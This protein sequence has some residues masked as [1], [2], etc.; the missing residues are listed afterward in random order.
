[1]KWENFPFSSVVVASS[2]CRWW[3]CVDCV[4]HS[5]N[6]LQSILVATRRRPFH[7][8]N[9]F[10]R[11]S[12]NYSDRNICHSV[13]S[14][15]VLSRWSVVRLCLRC[16]NVHVIRSTQRKIFVQKWK[17]RFAK[18]FGDLLCCSVHC[19]VCAWCDIE[20][21]NYAI[22][23]RYSVILHQSRVL[24]HSSIIFFPHAIDLFAITF[25]RF[26]G[27]IHVETCAR[28]PDKRPPFIHEIRSIP[29]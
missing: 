27:P 9:S 5:F 18:L 20:T 13:F 25:K 15:S 1:M 11:E 28:H 24:L 14:V 6:I 16:A 17:I 19:T 21:E 22:K 3:P 8:H 26:R 23:N 2:M 12:P 10:S 7:P 29:K 4:C